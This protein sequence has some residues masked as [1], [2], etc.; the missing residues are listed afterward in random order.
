MTLKFLEI[1]KIIDPK[2]L[3]MLLGEGD[4][5]S[6]PLQFPEVN[7]Q[8]ARWFS[9]LLWTRLDELSQTVEL[10]SGF[11]QRFASNIAV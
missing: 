5:T 1:D 4:W 2:I 11:Q 7:N 6:T 8:I 9:P 10:F 3:K